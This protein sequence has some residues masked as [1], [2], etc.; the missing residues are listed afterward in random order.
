MKTIDTL[1]PDI[2]Q[3]IQT[4]GW[5][6][7]SLAGSF[8][9]DVSRRLQSQ[10]GGQIRNASLRLSQMGPRCPRALWYSINHPEMAEA[11]PPWAEVKYS[12]G[13]IIEALAIT[14]AKASGHEVTGEQDELVL[15]GIV[16]HRDCVIDGCLVDVKS[17]S[18]ISF[19]KFKSKGFEKE[20]SFG[21]LDQL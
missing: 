7:D 17:A 12:F 20:D 8:A 15:D 9:T 1:I 13:H 14:L 2:Y 4:R 18:S 19:Q 6:H 11:L 16:G 21:Y 10:M 5:F 3:L